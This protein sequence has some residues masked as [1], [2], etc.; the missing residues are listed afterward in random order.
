L[1]LIY[2]GNANEPRHYGPPRVEEAD[3]VSDFSKTWDFVH[4]R[5]LRPAGNPDR[6]SGAWFWSVLMR[7]Q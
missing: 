6:T 4:L 1:M 3:L 5:E 2:A 7:R